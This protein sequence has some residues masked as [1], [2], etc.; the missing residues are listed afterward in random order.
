MSNPLFIENI[1]EYDI[2][3]LLETK[4]SDNIQLPNYNF[5]HCPSRKHITGGGVGLFISENLK[6]KIH[7]VKMTHSEYV[8]IKIDSCA[9]NLEQD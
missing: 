8:W 7:V 6:N 1:K 4:L 2:I 3:C 9:F 5:V